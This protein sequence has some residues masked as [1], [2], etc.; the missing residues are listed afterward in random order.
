MSANCV[1]TCACMSAWI[2]NSMVLLQ[3]IMSKICFML[4]SSCTC[5]LSIFH[6]LKFFLPHH[7]IDGNS[8]KII[9]MLWV[10]GERVT[11]NS[12]YLYWSIAFQFSFTCLRYS[13]GTLCGCTFL[14][15]YLA[16]YSLSGLTTW[17]Q[18]LL[19]HFLTCWWAVSYS[20][21]VFSP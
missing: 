18:G 11:L 12:D 2:C 8:S 7:M 6:D 21:R 15:R 17:P 16:F 20:D 13:Q 4:C 10:Q 14:L 5:I 19:P 9:D 3:S 1:F